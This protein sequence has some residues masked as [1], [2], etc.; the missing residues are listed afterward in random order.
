MYNL[1]FTFNDVSLLV[2]NDIS[3]GSGGTLNHLYSA[4]EKLKASVSYEGRTNVL[5]WYC[6]VGAYVGLPLGVEGSP[7]GKWLHDAR[8][9]RGR[10]SPP[11]WHP[12]VAGGSAS[13]QARLVKTVE[14]QQLPH[15][16]TMFP[17]A[18]MGILTIHMWPVLQVTHFYWYKMLWPLACFWNPASISGFTVIPWGNDK[19]REKKVLAAKQKVIVANAYAI[20]NINRT[21]GDI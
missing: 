1:P 13:E 10:W 21:V 16:T 20:R 11:S 4:E 9:V 18:C 8:V 15:S 2:S 3:R 6:L 14:V 7:G 12:L 17:Y 19:P 5:L